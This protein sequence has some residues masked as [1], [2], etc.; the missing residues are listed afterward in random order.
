[1][2]IATS[3]IT[4]SAGVANR[5]LMAFTTDAVAAA[6]TTFD[7][8]FKPREV[9]FVN[10][11]DRLTYEWAEGIP[12]TNTLDT[13]ANGDRT[14][15]NSTTIAV[16]SAGIVTVKAAAMVASKSFYVVAIG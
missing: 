5:C 15:G 3:N 2:G 12:A 9:R 7:F 4:Q 14:L 1:M 6:D 11:T 8:G 13:A 16:S 10:I